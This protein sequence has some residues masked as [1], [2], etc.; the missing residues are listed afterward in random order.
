MNTIPLTAG[1]PPPT[2]TTHTLAWGTASKYVLLVVSVGLGVV[3]MPFTVRHLGTADYG[4]WMLVASLT[5]YFQL[6]DLGYGSGIVRHLSE[7]DGQGDT[8]R[9]N[10]IASTFVVV[11]GLLGLA[12]LAGVGL[13]IVFVVPRFPNLAEDAV[14]RAQLLLG[15]MGL[16]IA[17]GLPMT[18]FGAVT[19]SRQRFALNNAVAVTVAVANAALTY[20]VLKSGYG[21]VTLV[22]S[23]TTLSIASYGLYAWTA[24]RAFPALRI[25]PSAYTGSIVREVTTFS[26]Y[27]F[28]IDIAVQLGFN[29]DNIVVG[30]AMGM[31]AVAV[32]SVSLR[33][34][35]YQRQLCGQLN[36]LLFPIV[37]RFS[38]AGQLDALRR[39]YLE[40]TRIAFTLVLGL[41]VCVIGLGGPL[42]R[43]WMGP[44]FEAGIVPLWILAVAGVVLVSQGPTGNVLLGTGRHRL[45][46]AVALGE[47]LANVALSVVLVRYYGLVGAA[48]GTAIPVIIANLTIMLPAACRVLD[49]RAGAFVRQVATAPLI[50]ALPSVL[51]CIALRTAAPPESLLMVFAEGAVVLA[52]YAVAFVGL[53]LKAETRDRYIAYFRAIQMRATAAPE[54]QP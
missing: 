22:A 20:L 19:M 28:V 35:E 39:T 31:P 3:L 25:R 52:T 44:E 14:P 33:I 10:Q 30:A 13:L 5:Y 36:G 17:I 49:L 43:Y 4:L 1:G 7:A 47:A 34:A 23:S 24:R 50:G 53:G 51:V 18:V 26:L 38:S 40:S 21:L 48:L 37:V 54:V 29:L 2:S 12:A 42:V 8:G 45:V 11:Y 27:F 15:I 6:F 32:Y 46:A 41:T 9:M 16:R